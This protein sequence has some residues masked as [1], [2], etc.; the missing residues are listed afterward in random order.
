LVKAIQII[1][2]QTKQLGWNYDARINSDRK[3]K[4]RLLD[5]FAFQVVG[6]KLTYYALKLVMP[7][8]SAT[9]VMGDHIKEGKIP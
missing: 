4:P 7:E 3:S 5:R 8:W 2:D 6:D 1:V 9:K